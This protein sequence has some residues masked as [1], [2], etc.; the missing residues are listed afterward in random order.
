MTRPTY[1]VTAL[2][3][4]HSFIKLSDRIAIITK[5]LTRPGKNGRRAR[6]V[7]AYFGFSS[8]DEAIAFITG[9]R[10]Y[11]P[12]AFCQA[13]PGQRLATAV[14]VKVRAFEGLERFTWELAAKPAIVATDITSE[15]A[16]AD[17]FPA[18]VA[19]AS[20][21]VKFP[22]RPGAALANRDRPTRVASGGV[23]V[24]ID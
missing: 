20:N 1:K 17:L 9:L 5:A 2:A 6:V 8:Q 21:V 10:R 19:I 4:R 12:K 3:D 22:S 18:P 14:E 16:K 15:Q 23:W 11:F 13:R 24:S 7:S